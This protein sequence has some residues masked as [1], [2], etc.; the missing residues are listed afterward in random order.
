ME[1]YLFRALRHGD[2]TEDERRKITAGWLLQCVR[3]SDGILRR[4]GIVVS[5]EVFGKL[6]S[7][8]IAGYSAR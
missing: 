8:K 3:G 2:L 7:K 4:H 1:I 5:E 6:S